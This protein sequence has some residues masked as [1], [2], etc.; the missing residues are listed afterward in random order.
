MLKQ[1]NRTKIATITV[2]A[3]VIL[4][5]AIVLPQMI[6][7]QTASD[8]VGNRPLGQFS[9][10]LPAKHPPAILLSDMYGN[11]SPSIDS[12]NQASGLSAKI[13]T[14]IPLGLELKTIRTKIDP[15]GGPMKMVTLIY[16]PK[17]SSFDVK[18]TMNDVLDYNGV[19]ALYMTD[20]STGD[21]A[22]WM[23]D[24]IASTPNTHAITIHGQNAIGTNGVSQNGMKSQVIFYDGNTEVILFS[25]GYS[26]SD[27]I[28]IAESMR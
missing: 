3:I 5:G 8:S 2:S 11:N 21:R 20:L 14:S 23:D 19:I 12:A 28:K 9:K 22:K 24:Y 15:D 13:A 4:I 1:E 25:V 16:A 26:E 18:T 6:H 27:L 10:Y 17:Q 7:T